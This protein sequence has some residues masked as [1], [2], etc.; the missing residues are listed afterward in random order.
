V[1]KIKPEFLDDGRFLGYY[2]QQALIIP[3]H[4]QVLITCQLLLS[5]T[6]GVKGEVRKL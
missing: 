3:C 5:E 4:L 2:I 1:Q 6:V